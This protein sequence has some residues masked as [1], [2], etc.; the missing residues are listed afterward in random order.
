MIK[1]VIFD[2]YST[3]VTLFGVGCE[4][5][6]SGDMALDAGVTPE[7]FRKVWRKT[8][9]A[10]TK[11]EIT[12]KEA[13]TDTLKELGRYSD[14]LLEKI[15]QK[16]VDSK[17]RAFQQEYIYPEIFLM[18]DEL[19]EKGIKIGLISNC[20]SEEAVQIR[21]SALFPYFDAAML[22]YEQH[23][24]KPDKEIYARC[25]KEL[26][27]EAKECLYVGDGGS[28]EL[29]AAGEIGMHPVQ[30]TWYADGV[31]E[32]Y[33]DRKPGYTKAE[34]PMDVVRLTEDGD[35]VYYAT[36]YGEVPKGDFVSTAPTY[37]AGKYFSLFHE[38]KFTYGDLTMKYYWYDPREHGWA[39][40]GKLSLI[41]FLHGTGN[42]L[43]GELC[44]N[45]TGAEFYA[46]ESYQRSLGGAFLL[47]PIANEWRDETGRT[48]GY[49]SKGYLEP[50]HAMILDFI[51]S[52]TQGVGL[53][54]LLGNS[55]GATF[56][57][58]L[59][60]Q[61]MDDFDIVIPVG[62][63]AL[64]DDSVLDL[65]DAKGK[66]LFFALGKRDEFHSFAKEAE[67]RIPRLQQMKRCFIYTPEWVRNG[68]G[69]IA[70]ICAGVEMGQ[71]CLVNAMH[72][73]LMFD[74]GSPM[75]ERLPKGVTGWIAQQKE[76]L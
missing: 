75:E 2:M 42:S 6:F 51:A 25:L 76:N 72:A 23:V 31:S 33:I 3:L 64:P 20:F 10:R 54:V 34:K 67:S 53:K 7:E 48:Q 35:N 50:V 59:M 52:K 36:W 12:S 28:G 1:A 57:L 62:S 74:D 22:S 37:E 18:L 26:G 39:D 55:S 46:S 8:E 17:S 9:D 56:V 45:Y 19:K 73:N 4:H 66:T 43:V 5:Y 29:E 38:G 14:E 71:H 41:T 60:D 11:G 47:I 44:I 68:D 32:G 13:L 21:E 70:S 15:Y 69:G 61:Y 63:T 40:D 49:W 27:L 58:R 16:R 30:A 65:Y 24:C